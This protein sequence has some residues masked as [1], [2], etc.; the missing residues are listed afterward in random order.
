MGLRADRVE[1][2]GIRTRDPGSVLRKTKVSIPGREGTELGR[3]MQGM[4][5]RGVWAV[6]GDRPVCTGDGQ[7]GGASN[8]LEERPWDPQLLRSK[9]RES[10]TS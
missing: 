5:K 7:A 8:N 2:R 6:G 10:S 3:C 1:L 4:Q 9:Q